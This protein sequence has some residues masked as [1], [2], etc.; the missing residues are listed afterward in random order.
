MSQPVCK[1]IIWT[2]CNKLFYT[3]VRR[4]LEFAENGKCDVYK[5]EKAAKTEYAVNSRYLHR[6]FYCPSPVFSFVLSNSRKGK[7]VMK[8]T[9]QSQI[10]HLY[11]YNADGE[12]YYIEYYLG[13]VITGREYIVW[14]KN[15]KYGYVFDNSG[16]LG[17]VSVEIYKDGLC[18]EYMWAHCY[19]ASLTEDE[20]QADFVHYESYK[21]SDSFLSTF[22]LCF[23][24]LIEEEFKMTL[25][26]SELV[27]LE[28][29]R[30]I[31]EGDRI[32]D[33]RKI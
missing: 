15:T 31:Y 22:V 30:T 5:A 28:K 13:D 21:Y 9:K 3:S 1:N 8:P 25:D 26:A 2:K 32:V 24:A 33:V 12:I 16:R 10:T 11:N 4:A 14:E 7:V 6:G 18:R 27:D 20:W 29:Y 23:V 19:N 17:G